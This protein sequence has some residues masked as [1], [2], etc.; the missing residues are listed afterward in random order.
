MCCATQHQQALTRENAAR[1]AP[2]AHNRTQH[3]DESVSRPMTETSPSSVEVFAGRQCATASNHRKW[4]PSMPEGPLKC[5]L[6]TASGG[7]PGN[8][9]VSL[10]WRWRGATVACGV[11]WVP[12]LGRRGPG[13]ADLVLLDDRKGRVGCPLAELVDHPVA[14]GTIQLL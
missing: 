9:A 8:R 11:S 7:Q 4:A 6:C 10:R 12:R 2:T 14:A 5:R 1:R 3:I 13:E